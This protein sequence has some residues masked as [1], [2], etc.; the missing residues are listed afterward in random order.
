MLSHPI[1]NLK[2]A[3]NVNRPTIVMYRDRGLPRLTAVDPDAM[4]SHSE[5]ELISLASKT[6]LSKSSGS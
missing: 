1:R 6:I 4:G 3:K 5:Q 2:L